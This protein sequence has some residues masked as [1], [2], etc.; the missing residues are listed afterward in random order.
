[1]KRIL[2][3]C[4]ALFGP[5]RLAAQ[6]PDLALT[7]V[8]RDSI[9]KTYHQIFPIWGRKAIERGFDLPTPL[10]F[11]IVAFGAKQDI[12]ISDLGLGFNAPADPVS[13]IKFSG[14]EAKLTNFSVR[15][16]LWVFPFLNFYAMLGKGPGR[17]TVHISEPVAFST[18]A[19][20]SGT[21]FG[22]GFT[23]A[24][25]IKRNFAVI[26]F[27]HQWAKSELLASPDR[28]SVV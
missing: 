10:G 23:G 17:T 15:T 27:N 20:F 22:L 5:L 6:N 24:F 26:D 9:L 25:G 3:S 18:E 4:L 21:N 13:F 16:D 1:M 8:E 11:N 14:A 19:K 7:Q 2:I 28:K 12:L